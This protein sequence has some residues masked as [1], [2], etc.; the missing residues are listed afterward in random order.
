[1]NPLLKDIVSEVESTTHSQKKKELIHERRK[2]FPS[3]NND[4]N[5]YLKILP[6]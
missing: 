3:H 5:E 6:R 1:M 2:K 4:L